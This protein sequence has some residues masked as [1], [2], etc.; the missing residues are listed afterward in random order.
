MIISQ[1][2]LL[3]QNTTMPPAVY[4][5]VLKIS[6]HARQMRDLISELLDFRKFDQHHIQLKLRKLE[7]NAFVQENYLSFLEYA[8][9]REIDY[10]L[11]S[12]VESATIWIDPWQMK[13]VLF[14]LLSN[15]FKHTQTKGSIRITVTESQEDVCI[16][17]QDSG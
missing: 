14:N 8:S 1:V 12:S 5:Q 2:E 13:K 16:A 10:R 15:A 17:I 9:G 3:L 7:L 6:K 4:N 11:Q